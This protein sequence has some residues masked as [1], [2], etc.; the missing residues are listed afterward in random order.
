MKLAL[1]SISKTFYDSIPP[2]KVID[3][4][5]LEVK[6]K[7]RIS[8]FGPNGCGKSTLFNIIAGFEQ[9]TEGTVLFD[10]GRKSRGQI[11]I[12]FI[13]QDHRNSILPWRTVLKNVELGLEF[14]EVDGN[15]RKKIAQHYLKKTGLLDFQNLYPYQLS[16]GMTQLIAFARTLAHQSDLLL[17]DEPFNSLD[18]K[19]YLN[20]LDG[21]QSLWLK[22]RKTTILITHNLDEAIFWSERV[23][24]LSPRPSRIVGDVRIGFPSSRKRNLL[25]SQNFMRIRNQ[26]LKICSKNIR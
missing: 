25:H 2:L 14:Q 16:G 4:F 21:L 22:N 7:E 26:I 23:I 24:I 18:Y 9:A 17:F 13:F 1:K 8:I 5:D 20:I 10:N 12:G 3:N 11:K 6:G 19:M 15:K